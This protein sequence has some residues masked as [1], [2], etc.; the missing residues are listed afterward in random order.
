MATVPHPPRQHRR[1]RRCSRAA[2]PAWSC[3][4]A[5]R[6]EAGLLAGALADRPLAA[7]VSSPRERALQ[8]AAPIAATQG[9]AVLEDAGFD[10]IDY[11]DWTGAAFASLEGTPA[12]RA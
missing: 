2:C 9:L 7:V 11:G 10:E 3:N 6:H 5:G 4:A 12:W 1:G 8:T